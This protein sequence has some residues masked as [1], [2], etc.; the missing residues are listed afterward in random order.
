MSDE[1]QDA[2][3]RIISA[4]AG[5]FARRGYAETSVRE[6]AAAA[7]VNLSMISYYFGSKQGVL[8]A[9]VRRHVERIAQAAADAHDMNVTPEERIRAFVR[10]LVDVFRSDP[11]VSRVVL[12]ELPRDV[13]EME[14]FKVSQGRR[15]LATAQTLVASIEDTPGRPFRFEIIGPA[16]AGAVAWHF[17]LRPFYEQV[18]E[19]SF[20]DAF[21]EAYPDQIA[22]L[23]MYGLIGRSREELDTGT[24]Q[25]AE[26]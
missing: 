13:P 22:E 6:L 16:L 7:N 3:Q 24:P 18:L 1:A 9:L 8:E 20:D 11:D 15:I 14:A 17:L 12:T 26:P 19:V 5:L 21:Y 25:K 2:K 23:L 10:R 4:A